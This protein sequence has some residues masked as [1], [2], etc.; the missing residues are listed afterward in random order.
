MSA[1]QVSTAQD[2]VS[3]LRGLAWLLPAL[4]VAAFGLA[5]T[6]ATGR[7]RQT[8][9]AAGLLLVLAG[10]V[11]LV[12]RVVAGNEVVD[13]LVKTDSV[14]PAAEDAWSI[15]THMLRD[16]AHATIIIGI[17]L[18]VAAWLAGPTAAAVWLRRAM[19]PTLRDR[20]DVAY[21]AAVVA[22]LV[23]IA[24]GPI[25]A[26]RMVVPILLMF[27]LALLGVAAL[28]RQTE[29]EFPEAR[30]GAAGATLQEQAGRA[31][32]AL[33]RGRSREGAAATPGNGAPAPEGDVAVGGGRSPGAARVDQLER[34]AAL[35][36]TGAL[37][38]DEFTAQKTRVLGDGASR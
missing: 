2:V 8:L 4:M 9:L 3:T 21:G 25:P 35:H 32:H 34:L 30:A 37:T 1:D 19:A 31:W 7:R 17:P 23:V 13:A 16:V 18:V 12:A 6:L 11:V 33:A 29:V 5:V 36:A 26:T 28:R 20:P 38:D 15:G 10:A 27:G 24:W 14:R 22:V